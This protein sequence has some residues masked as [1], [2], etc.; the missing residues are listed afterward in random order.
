MAGW[1]N[2][3]FNQGNGTKQTVL[4]WKR[5]CFMRPLARWEEMMKEAL[6]GT[7]PVSSLRPPRPCTWHTFPGYPT[8]FES[9]APLSSYE[10]A[11][12]HCKFYMKRALQ[13]KYPKNGTKMAMWTYTYTIHLPPPWISSLDRAVQVRALAGDIMLC[14]WAR[15]LTLTVPLSTQVYKWILVRTLRCTSIPSR[16]SG[17]TPSRFIL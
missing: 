5:D 17:N 13:R 2:L 16:R 15:Y 12:G 4:G 10:P 11:V 3:E 14:S 6:I 9:M 1:K 8:E 7:I